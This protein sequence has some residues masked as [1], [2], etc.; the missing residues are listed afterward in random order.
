MVSKGVFD[1]RGKGFLFTC[2]FALNHLYHF[3][4]PSRFV[5]PREFCPSFRVL[6]LTTFRNWI[7]FKH[8]SELAGLYPCQRQL[9]STYKSINHPTKAKLPKSLTLH[10]GTHIYIY[11]SSMYICVI[12]ISSTLGWS[13]SWVSRLFTGSALSAQSDANGEEHVML[14]DLRGSSSETRAIFP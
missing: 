11:I 8:V 9:F 7:P 14:R 3:D 6:G 13:V 4:L 2:Y 12:H 5:P 10:K 1:I